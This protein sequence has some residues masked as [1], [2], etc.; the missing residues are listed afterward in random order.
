MMRDDEPD[1]LRLDTRRVATVCTSVCPAEN[2]I[3]RPYSESSA[4]VTISGRSTLMRRVGRHQPVFVDRVG[5]L[6]VQVVLR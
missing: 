6:R 5:D 2:T 1:G 4:A 3:A